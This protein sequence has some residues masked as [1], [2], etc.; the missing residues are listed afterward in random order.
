MNDAGVSDPKGD[1]A[2]L[3]DVRGLRR[4]QIGVAISSIEA[5]QLHPAPTSKSGSSCR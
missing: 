3:G 2:L 5:R 4:N 1:Q